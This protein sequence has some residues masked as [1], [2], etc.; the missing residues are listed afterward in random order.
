VQE[1]GRHIGLFIADPYARADK[2][3]GAWMSSYRDQ[4]A[5]DAPITP[6]IV[7]T[8]NFTKS[9]PALLSYDDAET[10]FHEFGHALHG[11]LSQ[12]RYRSQS[13]TSVRRDFVELPSQIYEH[14]FSAPETLRRYA[15]H[16]ETGE[17]IP[18]KLIERLQA[19]ATFN[20]GF[21]TVEY[22]AAAILDMELHAQPNP[23]TIDI[24]AFERDL[25]ARL[26]MPAEIGVRHRPPHFQHLF[27]GSGYAA[28]Y[29]SYLWA[30]VL[31]ADGFRAFQEAGDLFDPAAA[32]G[33][34]RILQAGDTV[35]PMALFVAFRGKPPSVD[36]LLKHRGLVAELQGG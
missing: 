16:H 1:G 22:T 11:L 2:R 5:L 7:N 25:L 23:G 21:A 13:G 18:D 28:G 12:V 19:A 34:K 29:Y 30:E 20:Q 24:A 14:W 15:R 6:I 27:A 9:T 32:A 35:D 10:L 31:D 36:A 8:N 3:S 26:G 4:E 17:P 33:L